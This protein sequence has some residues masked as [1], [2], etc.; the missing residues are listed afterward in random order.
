MVYNNRPFILEGGFLWNKSI[1]TM[2]VFDFSGQ[3]LAFAI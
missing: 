1:P 3:P 2:P